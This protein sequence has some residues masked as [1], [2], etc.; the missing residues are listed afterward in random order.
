MVIVPPTLK[1]KHLIFTHTHLTRIKLIVDVWVRTRGPGLPRVT[2]IIHCGVYAKVIQCR[3]VVVT[4][5]TFCLWFP[6]RRQVYVYSCSW[7]G[8]NRMRMNNGFELIDIPCMQRVIISVGAIYSFFS[9]HLFEVIRCIIL[10]NTAFFYAIVK[11]VFLDIL[12]DILF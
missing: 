10:K 5:K 2:E 8:G 7:E 9:F 1:K 11:Q 4:T 12:I 3:T 6:L